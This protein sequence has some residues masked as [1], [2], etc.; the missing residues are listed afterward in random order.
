MSEV[1]TA[2]APAAAPVSISVAEAA[3]RYAASKAEAANTTSEAARVLGQQSAKAREERRAQAEKAAQEST[4]EVEDS[5]VADDPTLEGEARNDIETAN[6]DT[7]TE[8]A[9]TQDDPDTRTI[10]LGEGVSM[11]VAEVREN[12]LLKA[13]HTRRLQAMAEE[14]KTLESKFSQRLSDLD[15]TI[16]SLEPMKGKVKTRAEFI[17]EFGY[18]EGLDKWDEHTSRVNAAKQLAH[19][20]RTKAQQDA[21]AKAEQDCDQYLVENYNKEWADPAKYEAAQVEIT[22]FAK[23]LGFTS[24]QIFGLG[25]LPGALI[26]LDE[27]RQFRALKASGETVK[28][29][30]A[31]KPKVIRPGAKVSAQAGAHSSVQTAT[32]KL[33]SSGS[34]AD[35][36]ALLQASRRVR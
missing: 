12:I 36:V 29:A 24:E 33:K 25:V 28:R 19:Q 5:N 17:E 2:P 21:R 6:A 22:K 34:I 20:T 35:A 14:R 9:E 30:I 1:Q 7:P 32:A 11:T 18:A 10:D 15:K 8:A 31:D 27:A 23:S 3:Q 26:A 4:E 13:D 16:A